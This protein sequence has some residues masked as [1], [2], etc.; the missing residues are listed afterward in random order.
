MGSPAPLPLA[1][2]QPAQQE[3]LL[4][5]VLNISPELASLLDTGQLVL[6]GFKT[7]V[8]ALGNVRIVPQI[9]L[10]E[11]PTGPAG[12]SAL[13]VR[14]L[15]I[16][17]AQ[18]QQQLAQE[19]EFGKVGAASGLLETLLDVQRE[20][21]SV[22]PAL[23]TFGAAGGGTRAPNAA[24]ALTQGQGIAPELGGV[25]NRLLGEITQFA[26]A[27]PINPNTG[28]AF[29]PGEMQFLRVVDQQRT[30][31]QPAGIVDQVLPTT[32]AA[33]KPIRQPAQVSPL[34]QARR[35]SVNQ[36]VRGALTNGR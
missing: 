25:V 23:T 13:D 16:S 32:I 26:G 8:D 35:S 29:T 15:D 27:N 18:F 22:V 1:P 19:E 7:E 31:Q 10:P 21:F 5:T 4:Q 34:T 36:T 30:T 12:P 20:P 24:L 6:K 3:D 17:E 9:G 11:A 28:V 33:A 14:A 2:G